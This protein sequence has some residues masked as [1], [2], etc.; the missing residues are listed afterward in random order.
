MASERLG[1][2]EAEALSHGSPLARD[3]RITLRLAGLGI[4]IA[5]TRNAMQ[6]FGSRD[7][8]V[9]NSHIA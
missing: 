1:Y 2:I 6:G 8:S 4:L 7:A 5:R 9:S 3:F